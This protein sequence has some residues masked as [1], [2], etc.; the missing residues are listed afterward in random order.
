MVTHQNATNDLYRSFESTTYLLLYGA[1]FTGTAGVS[2]IPHIAG[3]ALTISSAKRFIFG[4]PGHYDYFISEQEVKHPHNNISSEV[5]L[6]EA[7]KLNTTLIEYN[8]N[9]HR[10]QLLHRRYIV[11]VCPTSS[12]LKTKKKITSVVRT[13]GLCTKAT[14]AQAPHLSVTSLL[15]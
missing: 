4:K 11:R 3:I 2:S 10:L 8:D 1:F 6:I 14:R 9:N 7:R 15:L 5:H 13:R 12:D